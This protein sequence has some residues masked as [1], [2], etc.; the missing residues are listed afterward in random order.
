MVL[1][2]DRQRGNQGKTK[3]PAAENEDW[4]TTRMQNR[5]PKKKHEKKNRRGEIEL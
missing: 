4:A 3:K 1:F 5:E 2:P